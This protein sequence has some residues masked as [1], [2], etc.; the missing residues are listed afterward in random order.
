MPSSSF[1]AAAAYLSTASSLSKV[2][3]TI[4]L[5]LYGLFK[6]VTAGPTPTSSR[7]SIFDMTGRAKWDAWNAAG[8]AYTQAQDAET[9]YL[10]IAKELGWDEQAAVSKQHEAPSTT[11][12]DEDGDIWDSEE[13]VSSQGGGGLGCAVSTMAYTKEESEKT[14]HGFAVEN[15]LKGI[16]DLLSLVP[17][18]N[19]DELDEHGYTP[20][21]LAADRGHLDIVKLLLSK[22]VDKSIKDPDD[23]AALELARIVG[24]REIVS[25]LSE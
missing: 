12:E 8:K 16:E 1:E 21:H 15:N 24:H 10:E 23:M 18:L 2:S 25:L 19:L 3:N 5:E 22:G 11:N 4:K 9:R 20:L 17:D 6:Y 7:P 14:L 13:D